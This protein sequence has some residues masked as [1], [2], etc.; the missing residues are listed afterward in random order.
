FGQ[1]KKRCGPRA[2]IL[3]TVAGSVPQNFSSFANSASA[4]PPSRS[5]TNTRDLSPVAMPMLQSGFPR[6]H[7]A[8]L[9]GSVVA[10]STPWAQA[11]VFPP[12]GGSVTAATACLVNLIRSGSVGVEF[13]WVVGCSVVF[14]MCDFG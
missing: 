8:I 4:S 14:D 10:S 9:F 13:I 7:P 12:P 6:H 5:T 2:V 11:G 3:S 1:E